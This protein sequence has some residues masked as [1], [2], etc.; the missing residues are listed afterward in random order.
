M[1][2]CDITVREE[3]IN[4]SAN[5]RIELFGN[6]APHEIVVERFVRFSNGL[7]VPGIVVFAGIQ[8]ILLYLIVVD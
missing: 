1:F 6:G 3:P 8:E 7:A 2:D 5:G 4:A